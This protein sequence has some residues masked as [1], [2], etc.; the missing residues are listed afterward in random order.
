MALYEATFSIRSY[1][2]FIHNLTGHPDDQYMKFSFLIPSKNRLELLAHAVNSI[3]RQ[4][5][6]NLEII[7]TDNASE[8]DYASYVNSIGDN[9]I[10][11]SRSP[12]SVSVTQN[13]NNALSLASGDYILMLGDDDALTPG[14][15]RKVLRLIEEMGPPD[16]LFF[17][18]YH[19]L[20]PDVILTSPRGYL[21]DVRNSDFFEGQD[22]PFTL[23]PEQAHRVATAV[24]D[25]RYLFGFN[26]QHFMFRS[27]FLKE[28]SSSSIGSI[29]QSPYPDTFAA[30]VSFLKAKTIV[31]V[32]YP[33]VMIGISPKSFG[34]YYF[35]NLRTEGS[36]FLNN[37][38][39]S[40]DIRT[41][42]SNIVL[43]GNSN[44]TNWLV[45][46]EA[47]RKALSPE[48]DFQINV[49]RYR[50]LQIVAFLRDTYIT[51]L[52]KIR[53][54]DQISSKL[55]RSEGIFL[56]LLLTAIN[57]KHTNKARLTR[58]F[59]AWDKTLAQFFPAKISM[60]DIGRHKSISDAFNWLE[61]HPGPIRPPRLFSIYSLHRIA[62][63]M[64][65]RLSS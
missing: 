22:T 13:W 29:F 21:A 12:T 3:R 46:A 65:R 23:L 58:M 55:S 30:V 1:F 60:L 25:M 17:A 41:S 54:L 57:S 36:D 5:H 34:Y 56:T 64:K 33:M 18:A 62:A 37:E 43:P 44:N 9:R 20:Y 40:P 53:E 4:D 31:V 8:Q 15:I 11:Y 16:I 24:F 50:V 14:F 27:E 45:A 10:I 52:H 32:P 51:K 47:A 49:D 28:I 63:A 7:I 42:L 38:T 6:N 48:F 61:K 2:D 26:S 59:D 19:Y 39:V 35:N